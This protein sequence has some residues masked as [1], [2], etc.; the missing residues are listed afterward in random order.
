MHNLGISALTHIRRVVIPYTPR[1]LFRPYHERRQRWA[2]LVVHRRGG[3]TVAA[4][5]D[6]VRKAV[7]LALPDGR[8]GYI[9]PQLNQAKDVAWNYLKRYTAPLAPRVNESELWV[10]VP[11]A[12]GSVS[13]IRIYGADNPDRLRGGYFDDALIDE[14]A[15]MAPSV[16]GEIIRPMLADRGGSATFIGTIKGRN[17][18]HALH[19]ARKDD[20]DWFTMY[21]RASGTGIIPP[22]ELEAMRADMSEAQYAQEMELDPDAAIVGAYWGK[23]L[24]AA[25]AAGR[26]VLVP[27]A[28][29]PVHTVWDLGIGDS[30]AIWFWQAV[31]SEIRI[32]DFY[33]NH[34]FGLDH[35]AAVIAS[36]G[37]A[38][39]DDW[40]PH[41]ARV[42]E[43]G[44]GRTRVET[45]RK[46]GLRPRLVPDHRV[47]DGIN[48]A[49]LLIPRM[50]FNTPDT[51]DGVEGL[52]QYRADYD[53]KLRTFRDKPRHDWTSHRAD[54]FRYLAM[55]YREIVPKPVPEAGRKLM[56]G[57]LNEAR[58]EDMWPKPSRVPKRI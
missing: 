35:Y 23:E 1:G 18:L 48:A 54:A 25:E 7:R 17:H 15:D 44:T 5:N 8:L 14:Y 40:V 19:D 39:G 32:L 30:T 29:A 46:M 3:K 45:M 53:D 9:A 41:D 50:W 2:C 4:V 26:M 16:F 58:L 13:R 49:R 31:G 10:E 24:A 12:A 21:A 55:A 43:L 42:R 57:A 11:N 27:V 37:W 6:Q 56:V 22:A 34:G 38:R 47:E 36:K 52:K 51:R 20:P 33:E 28:D